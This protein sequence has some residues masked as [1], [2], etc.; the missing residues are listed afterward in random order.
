MGVK[1]FLSLVLPDDGYYIVA[2][3]L[4]SGGFKHVA[5][6]DL[7]MVLEQC[8]G[9][10]FDQRDVYF[11]LGSFRE[12]KIW[13]ANKSNKDGTK[14][15]WVTR[16]AAN[17]VSMRALFLDLDIDPAKPEKYPTQKAAVVDLAKFCD[18]LQLPRPALVN[19][20][21]GVHVYWPFNANV[22]RD[23]WKPIATKLNAACA[24]WG[25]KVDG[26]ITADAA[27]VLRVPSTYNHKRGTTR[28]V[29]LHSTRGPYSVTDLDDTLTAYLVA[30]NAATAATPS[31]PPPLSIPGRPPIDIEG[32]IGVTDNPLNPDLVAYMCP[33]FAKAT[34]TRGATLSEPQWYH[35]L[36]LAK[37]CEQPDRVMLAVSDGHKGFSLASMQAKAANWSGSPPTCTSIWG[38]DNKTCEGCDNWRRIKSPASVGFTIQ[39]YSLP[40]TVLATAT[41]TMVLP[42]PPEP[43]AIV[44]ND[45]G[46]HYIGIKSEDT[47]TGA[48]HVE[49]IVPFM[50]Y[51]TRVLRQT[52]IDD[53]VEENCIWVA[54]LPRVGKVQLKLPVGILSDTR[55]LHTEMLTQGLHLDQEEAKGTP[56]YM[57]AYLKQ[58]ARLA[59]REKVYERLGWQDDNRCFVLPYNI[60]HR[61]GSVTPHACS[62]SIKAI[63]KDA[64]RPKGTL[65]AW[66]DALLF[67]K[68]LPKA[69]FRFF[70]FCEFGSPL[71]HMTG[72]K[73]LL[74]AANG[75]SGRGKST[76]LEACATVWGDG[77][78]QMI[79]GGQDGT[80]TNALY[81]IIGTYHSMAIKLDDTTER[82]PDEIAKFL[83]NI[84]QGKGK[85]R[86]AHH[87]HDGR[88]VTWQTMVLSSSNTDEINNLIT[89]GKNRSPHLMRMIAVEFDHT[90]VTTEEKIAAD[91][92]KA[93]LRDNYGHAGPAF[94]AYVVKHYDDVKRRVLKTMENIDRV[95]NVESPERFISAA[96]ACA[97]VGGEIAFELGLI[98]FRPKDDI[99]WIVGNV[100]TMREAH[101]AA[102]NDPADFLNE[103]FNDK[104]GYTLVVSPKGSS[105]LDNIANK[106]QGRLVIRHEQDKARA[107][108]SKPAFKQY[109]SEKKASFRTVENELLLAGAITRREAYKTLGDETA[110]GTTQT[111][112]W[113]IDMDILRSI[114]GAK[115]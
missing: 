53:S 103:F 18:E 28:P 63:T 69:N 29:R 25:L 78:P 80:T 96:L 75:E 111:R 85:E 42:D 23:D 1:D 64:I 49:S 26:K 77:E 62:P 65:D 11:A 76:V 114:T 35:M 73:G 52:N 100:S 88:V 74:V 61:D 71:L 51:P 44:K 50:F 67:Y 95:V 45:H 107:Y 72:H 40:A 105:N 99:D 59:D 12:P 113:E 70:M 90:A 15:G 54:H 106:P 60:Y 8:A 34:T 20:G 24:M 84:S 10:V 68:E 38:T 92:M 14:G 98:P 89:S 21:Y 33:A 101:K 4:A 16:T 66:R 41:G 47:K 57:T 13:Q 112:C 32:N 109:C 46:E 81:S 19:S 104:V 55:K 6:T 30:N 91:H 82:D 31:R 79:S 97:V 83:I 110:Y 5:S 2:A 56:K 108:I 37:Y 17:V 87:E 27:R 94:I 58:L 7:D 36:G 102:E 43:Y 39:Q 115:K 22:A 48:Q 9:W 3:P 93:A 86:M